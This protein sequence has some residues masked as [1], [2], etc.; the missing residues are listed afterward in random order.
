MRIEIRSSLSNGKE[1]FEFELL[2]GPGEIEHVKG[3]SN[4]L[5]NAFTKVLEWRE[6]IALDYQPDD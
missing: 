3:Y 5:I 2:D 4:D 6:R 1:F